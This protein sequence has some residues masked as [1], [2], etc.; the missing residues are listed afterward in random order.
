M[1]TYPVTV[2]E[3]ALVAITRALAGAGVGLLLAGRLTGEARRALG[4]ALL[5]IGAVTS[6]PL[7]LTLLG[8]RTRDSVD[9]TG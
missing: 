1:K 8:S 5:A 9:R 3:V 2:P 4:V 7:V 6:I